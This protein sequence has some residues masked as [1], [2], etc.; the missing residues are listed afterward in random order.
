M[1]HRSILCVKSCIVL[2]EISS[3]ENTGSPVSKVTQFCG[4]RFSLSYSPEIECAGPEHV[5]KTQ[6]SGLAILNVII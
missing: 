3:S 2:F 4:S 6:S 1:S 5:M